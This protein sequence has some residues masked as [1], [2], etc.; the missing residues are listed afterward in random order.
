MA[1]RK[2]EFYEGAAIHQLARAGGIESLRHDPPFFF[3][4]DRLLIYLKY[5]TKGRSPWAFTFTPD[6]QALLE[7]RA[8]KCAVVIGMVCG[9]DGIAA[10]SYECYNTIAKLKKSAIHISCYRRHGQHYS[11]GGPDGELQ[12]KVAPSLWQRILMNGGTN[13]AL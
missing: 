9:A 2:H 1:I 7:E 5:S 11:I 10:I 6:E 12:R 3:V 8:G 4:N 13:E